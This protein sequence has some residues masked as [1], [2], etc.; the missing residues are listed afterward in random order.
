MPIDFIHDCTVKTAHPNWFWL[1]FLRLYSGPGFSLYEDIDLRRVT[2]RQLYCFAIEV[3][4]GANVIRRKA[5]YQIQ[6]LAYWPKQQQEYVF[7][8][9]E[10]VDKN[11]LEA[12]NPRRDTSTVPS[13]L[14]PQEW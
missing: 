9:I 4:F 11:N 3:G 14:R 1:L 8:H 5:R 10:F 6:P 12:Q 13:K 2:A 7:Q